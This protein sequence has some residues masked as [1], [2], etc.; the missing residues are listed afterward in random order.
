[1]VVVM[2]KDGAQPLDYYRTNLIANIKPDNWDKG[3]SYQYIENPELI[4][5]GDFDEHGLYT[6]PGFSVTRNTGSWDTIG[7]DISKAVLIM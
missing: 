7:P 1:M 4:K 2:E 6:Q 3:S 5:L